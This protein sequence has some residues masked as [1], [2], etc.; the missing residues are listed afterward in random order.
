M[1]ALLQNRWWVVFASASGLLVGA[2]AINVFAFGVF[3]KPI[4]ED[5]GLG[6]GLFSSAIT[7]SSLMNAL[8]CPLL[9]W[10]IDRWGA[11]RV[12]I[13]GILLCALATASY[14]LLQSS[15]LRIYVIFAVVG[16]VFGCQTPIA[17]ATVTAQWFDKKRGLAL[18][19]AMAGV[20]LGV[21]LIPQIAAALIAN[22]GWRTAFLGL[23]ACV[24]GF[25]FIPVAL[26]IREP[27]GFVGSVERQKNAALRNAVPGVEGREAFR[28]R[29][30]Y[31]LTAAF[32]LAI[33]AINGTVTHVVAL[34]TDRGIP[35]QVA[36]G[37]LSASGLAII[38]GRILSGWCLDRFWGPYVAAGFFVLPMIGIGLLDSG[39]A[40]MV[41]VIGAA[42][43]GLGI[44]AEVDLMA[45]F[46]S[47]YF[48]L[49]DYAKIYGTM[50]AVFSFGVGVGPGISGQVFDRF[51]SYD[52]VCM[53][54]EVLLAI[55]CLLFLR[56]GPYPYPP[57]QDIPTIAG[58]QQ[59][60]A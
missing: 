41:P 21:A 42:L 2:G 19:L 43:C 17:Y 56:L 40:G 26:F 36:T 1:P 52:P 14:G 44:G 18:G 59:Q 37:A 4:T 11:R 22:F 45:F 39:A 15:P 57:R 24:L 32:F 20:G 47:R 13:P 12:M 33:V 54:Y 53:F 3:L 8:A 60:P 6:R 16:F 50:F 27:P 10:M 23:A 31:A 30:F 25:A 9:G 58:E 34:L 29:Q 49:R 38:F 35:L 7:L 55:T 48:G 28:S 5:L 46:V 51:H